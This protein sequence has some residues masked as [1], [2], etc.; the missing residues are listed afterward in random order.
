MDWWMDRQAGRQVE[1]INIFRNSR[2]RER[3]RERVSIFFCSIVVA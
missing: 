1:S 2:E 3:E